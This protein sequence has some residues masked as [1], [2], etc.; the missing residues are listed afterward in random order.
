[1]VKPMRRFL[2]LLGLL[3]A[4]PARA[5]LYV[6]GAT[7]LPSLLCAPQMQQH[8]YGGNGL[9]LVQNLTMQGA[10]VGIIGSG[11]SGPTGWIISYP[12]GQITAS[13]VAVGVEAGMPY[14]DIN[15]SG[16]PTSNAVIR[17]NPVNGVPAAAGQ[18]WTFGSYVTLQSG[19][20]VGTAYRLLTYNPSGN[21]AFSFTPQTGSLAQNGRFYTTPALPSGTTFFNFSAVGI[22][23]SASTSINE[24][25]RIGLP[26]LTQVQ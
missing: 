10:V 5:A 6:P 13:I 11:G 7:C 24:T 14:F 2:F 15:F 19:T 16:T 18:L 22:N 1:M 20:P 9:N 26:F 8:F 12:N 4:L 23:V 25:L 17:I 21:T 3:L